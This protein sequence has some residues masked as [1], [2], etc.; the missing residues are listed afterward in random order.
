MVGNQIYREALPVRGWLFCLVFSGISLT[1][2]GQEGFR[3]HP[4]LQNPAATSMTVIWFSE[5]GN[6]GILLYKERDSSE[7]R[8]VLSTPVPATA[9]AYPEWEATMF[10]GGDP[11]APPF[12]HRI[13]LENLDPSTTYEYRVVQDQDDYGASFRTAPG[14]DSA[15][16]FIVYADSETEPESTGKFVEWIDQETG[17]RRPYMVDQTRGYRN[18]IQ[19]IRE[20]DP[21]LVIVAGDLVEN[22]GEQRDWDEFW[23]HN[24]GGGPVAGLAGGVPILP[25]LGNHEYYGGTSM[26]GWNQP[27]SEIAVARYLSYFEV[28]ANNSPVAGQEGRYYTLEYGPAR[29]IVLDVNNNSPHQ[30]ADD[31]NFYQLGENDQGGGAAPDFLVGSRQYQWMEEQLARGQEEAH[32]T[33][34]IMHH[35]PYTSGFHGLPPGF[36]T[37]QDPWSSVPVRQLTPVLM[38]YGVDAVFSG[39]DEIWERSEVLGTEI[40]PDGAEVPHTIHFYDV[41]VGGDGLRSP[42]N[43]VENPNAA[44]I[45]HRDAPEVWVDS[46][47][48]SGGKHYGHLEVEIK[49]PGGEGMQAILTPVYLLP[50][51]DSTGEFSLYGRKEYDDRVVLMGARDTSGVPSVLGTIDKDWGQPLL[52]TN[53]FPNPF[54]NRIRIGC[55]IRGEG[56]VTFSIC[57]M[58]GKVVHSGSF[59]EKEPGSYQVTW[60]GSDGDGRPL[61]PGIYCLSFRTE[62]GYSESTRI[63]KL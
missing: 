61:P 31:T 55:S 51:K 26:G 35:A 39:H 13:R 9:L 12:R 29:F 27:A 43:T 16:R 23:R 34:V 6:A 60:D 2:S 4:Y 45:A 50:I 30:S 20:R 21:D 14:G 33:F 5:T 32:F 19:V 11:P 56:H 3:L 44:F 38:R 40:T 17:L 22:G 48:V 24:A 54:R 53:C 28:P 25:A 8:E 49:R 36:D 47:L 18:N 41:G 1:A 63:V 10:F 59:R 62:D 7:F 46:I 57:D 58:F 42:Y 52:I 37:Y 15:I